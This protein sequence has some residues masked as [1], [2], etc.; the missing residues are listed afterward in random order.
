[1]T[2]L[3][4]RGLIGAIICAPAI[5]RASSLMPVKAAKALGVFSQPWSYV[6]HTHFPPLRYYPYLVQAE[7]D[8]LDRAEAYFS[9]DPKHAFQRLDV[10]VTDCVPPHI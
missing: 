5:V 3:S 1:M 10:S 2:A 8:W 9:L 6:D 4:R 7:T